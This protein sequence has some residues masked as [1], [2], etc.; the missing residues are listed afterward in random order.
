MVSEKKKRNVLARSKS[1]LISKRLTLRLKKK[2]LS[3]N[4][5]E[6]IN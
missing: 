5:K 1:V 3:W 4:K 2:L 6:L